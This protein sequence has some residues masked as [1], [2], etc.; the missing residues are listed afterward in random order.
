VTL[1]Q[2]KSIEIVHELEVNEGEVWSEAKVYT[3]Q[4][5]VDTGEPL[6]A[7]VEHTRRMANGNKVVQREVRDA[8]GRLLDENTNVAGDSLR[9]F[10]RQWHHSWKPRLDRTLL[11]EYEDATLAR[12]K[13]CNKSLRPSH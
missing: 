5:S 13:H 2:S 6:Q 7:T 8:S 1:I 11:R 12:A 4:W 10:N 9:E 3:D